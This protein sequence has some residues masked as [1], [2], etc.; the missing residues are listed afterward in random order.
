MS[1]PDLGFSP[2]IQPDLWML[3]LSSAFASARLIRFHRSVC[4]QALLR[5]IKKLFHAN[6]AEMYSIM[7]SVEPW[8]AHKNKDFIDFFMADGVEAYVCASCW[9]PLWQVWAGTSQPITTHVLSGGLLWQSVK[10]QPLR[11]GPT[12][13][14]GTLRTRPA[15]SLLVLMY[16]FPPLGPGREGGARLSTEGQSG[17][18]EAWWSISQPCWCAGPRNPS[19]H[20]VLVPG[21]KCCTFDS[22][23]VAL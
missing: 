19:S 4:L 17:G 5:Q 18:G 12:C 15:S 20:W 13:S 22:V 6:A 16:D 8:A 2:P 7:G 9:V 3:D 23:G 1:E 11:P 10:L 14:L 21:A